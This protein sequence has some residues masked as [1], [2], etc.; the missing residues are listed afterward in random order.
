MPRNSGFTL[1]EALA[2]VTIIT[3]LATL[4]LKVGQSVLQA[5]R[6][7][8]CVASLRILHQGALAYANDH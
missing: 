6:S 7:M 3:I 4:G 5:A 2:A 8:R 1:L